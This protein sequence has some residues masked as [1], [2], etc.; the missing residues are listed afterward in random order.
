M[1]FEEPTTGFEAPK[2]DNAVRLS[3]FVLAALTAIFALLVGPLAA[4]AG[5]SGLL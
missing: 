4:L 3:V 1:F 5:S 2:A